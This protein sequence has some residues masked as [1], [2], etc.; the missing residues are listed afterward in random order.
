MTLNL[1]ASFNRAALIAGVLGMAAAG[2]TGPAAAQSTEQQSAPS[3]EAQGV[4]Q[5][6]QSMQQEMQQLMSELR[7]IQQNATEA[8]PEL[9]AEQDEYRDL[10]IDT[11]SDQDFDAEAEMQELQSL[12]AELQG[13][14]QLGEEERQA[15][16]QQLEQKSQQFRSKQQQAMQTE[17]VATARQELDQKMRAAMKDQNPEAAELIT[18]LDALQEKY[19]ALLQKAMQQ[20][21]QGSAGSPEG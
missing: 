16:M 15:K 10:V 20:Q 3:P 5:E 4:M 21:Q 19:R 2:F 11:M 1:R 13:S 14:D 18:Q 17:A 9:A 12:Q 7:Q 6:L 8:N